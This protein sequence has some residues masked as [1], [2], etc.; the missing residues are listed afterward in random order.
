MPQ[1][2]CANRLVEA[3]GSDFTTMGYVL[4]SISGMMLLMVL[5]SMPMCHFSKKK[6]E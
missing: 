2:S 4:S 3:I 6:Q 5:L 1:V